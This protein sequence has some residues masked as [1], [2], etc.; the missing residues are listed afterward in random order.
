MINSDDSSVYW[1]SLILSVVE[2]KGGNALKFWL[3]FLCVTGKILSDDSPLK[4]YKIDEKNFVVVMVT[5][6]WELGIV[7]VNC[8]CSLS[9]TSCD[10]SVERHVLAYYEYKLILD[11][12][13]AFPTTCLLLNILF[14]TG[15]SAHSMISTVW[16]EGHCLALLSIPLHGKLVVPSRDYPQNVQE[17]L[18]YDFFFFKFF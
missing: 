1:H 15:T 3:F 8:R 13:S 11:Y 12:D 18:F 10:V 17:L 4:E 9:S 2:V 16:I 5:K 14:C 7:L 6:V